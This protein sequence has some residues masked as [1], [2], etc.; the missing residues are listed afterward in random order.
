MYFESNLLQAFSG[1]SMEIP[2]EVKKYQ[3]VRGDD[4]KNKRVKTK[5]N[6][7][8]VKDT[9]LGTM[10]LYRSDPGPAFQLKEANGRDPS[11]QAFTLKAVLAPKNT[12]GMSRSKADEYSQMVTKAE[13]RQSILKAL[14]WVVVRHLDSEN[15]SLLWKTD[16]ELIK[17]TASFS[18][19]YGRQG[20]KNLENRVTYTNCLLQLF[21]CDAVLE[22]DARVRKAR[23]EA[24]ADVLP[25]GNRATAKGKDKGYA[26]SDRLSSVLDAMSI[27]AQKRE[28]RIEY[29]KRVTLDE[30]QQALLKQK[31]DFKK[32]NDIL[33]AGKKKVTFDTEK[34]SEKQKENEKG[35]DGN[36]V[37]QEE[38]A[39][40]I[41]YLNA[42]DEIIEG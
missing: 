10:S 9:V 23:K 40:A 39:I 24:R 14:M 6:N 36:R 42:L 25:K 1:F 22:Q 3:V 34:K 15:F 31:E 29:A 5:R 19:E 7:P 27:A 18:S 37:T 13:N 21:N 17:T 20:L 4:G 32:V 26:L 33:E 11:A 16:G 30:N 38:V 28:Q 2:Q 41:Q 8:A 35:E 12:E